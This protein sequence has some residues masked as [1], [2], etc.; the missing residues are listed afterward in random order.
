MVK[1]FRTLALFLKY[2][3]EELW[4]PVL[5]L[6][7]FVLLCWGDK[8]LFCNCLN[9]TGVDALVIPLGLFGW[10]MSAIW[11]KPAC[12]YLYHRVRGDVYSYNSAD[13]WMLIVGIYAGFIASVV[14]FPWAAEMADA[15]TA[16][17]G[18]F[19]AGLLVGMLVAGTLLIG[20][21]L[22]VIADDTWRFFRSNW[23][24]AVWAVEHKE[25][26]ASQPTEK[27]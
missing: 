14:S 19:F 17:A 13:E 7:I 6:T 4:Q 26:M 22:L 10:V 16:F 24:R 8:W 21:I 27:E 1:F 18:P 11:A 23:N 20:N 5:G 12:V 25:Y 15:D 9:L 3:A 2:K